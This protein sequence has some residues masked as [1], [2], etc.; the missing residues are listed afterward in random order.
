[1][2]QLI[3]S[4]LSLAVLCG[5]VAGARPTL[6][7]DALG[8]RTVVVPRT[9][10]T[11]DENTG[12]VR[13]TETPQVSQPGGVFGTGGTGTATTTD[14]GTA[15]STTAPPKVRI[16]REDCV[17]LLRD[18]ANASASYMPGVD[19]HGRRVAP[20]DAGAS[21]VDV[22][23]NKVAPA[24]LNG[25]FKLT[26]PTV[27][28][29][30]V[31]KDLSRYLKGPEKQLAA[32]K[33]A[34]LAANKSQAATDAAVSSAALSLAGAQSAYDSAAA[35]A[36]SAQAAADADP[37]NTTL[38]AAAASAQATADTA[39]T[40]L[41]SAQSSYDTTTAAASANNVDAALAGANA[42]LSAAEGI[43]YT[44]DSTAETASATAT[45]AAS[46]S[47]AADA[48]ALEART[49]VA[50]SNNMELNIGTVRFDT[51]T[52]AMT[53]NGQP[54]NDAARNELAARCRKMLA[55]EGQ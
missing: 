3:L 51:T 39:A 35:A 44:Q 30:N 21:D 29:F 26:L 38:A 24:D 41:A 12:T 48:A 7:D 42:T 10:I 50:K 16:S 19:A 14:Q 33:A 53:F 34:A 9:H 31:T 17:R 23:G 22:H 28:E 52:G 49:T 54:I 27:Y 36:T 25:G 45:S 55:E 4:A 1:M 32:E 40:G 37:T 6:A 18:Y 5:A 8:A 47:S 43:G 11:V 15:Q 46:E 13:T 20:A 2:R